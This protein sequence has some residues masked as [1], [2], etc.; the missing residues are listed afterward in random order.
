MNQVN[1]R[2]VC[3]KLSEVTVKTSGSDISISRVLG[4]KADIP[5]SGRWRM[6]TNNDE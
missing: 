3:T 4:L 6:Q 5:G 1:E 2:L